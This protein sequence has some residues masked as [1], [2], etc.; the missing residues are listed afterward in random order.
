MEGYLFVAEG[1]TS[2]STKLNN[3]L[4]QTTYSASAIN[5]VATLDVS[6]INLSSYDKIL[7]GYGISKVLFAN[8]TSS[9]SIIEKWSKPSVLYNTT[10]LLTNPFFSYYKAAG[11]KFSLL[12]LAS[13]PKH[14][15]LYYVA[16]ESGSAFNS[17]MILEATF[18]S[19]TAAPTTLNTVLDK[20]NNDFDKM[21]PIIQ[22]LP[23][24]GFY[25]DGGNM[26]LF[27]K[28]CCIGDSLTRVYVL[29]K[30]IK[31]DLLQIMKVPLL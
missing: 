22:S 31:M 1:V 27:K 8:G 20:F 19:A 26:A 21:T 14:A 9:T 5:T 29:S 24:Q 12:G 30:K 2:T 10:A 16:Y 18:Y 6:N 3:I 28:I 7:V 4:A 15:E 13:N 25:A 23:N 11:D 17:Q